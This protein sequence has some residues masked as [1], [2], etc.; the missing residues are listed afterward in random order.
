M[1]TEFFNVLQYTIKP[2][3]DKFPHFMHMVFF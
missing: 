2:I 3:L 1:K